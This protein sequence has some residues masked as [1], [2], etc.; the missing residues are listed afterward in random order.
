MHQLRLLEMLVRRKTAVIKYYDFKLGK[1]HL[2]GYGWP[3]LVALGILWIPLIVGTLAI[4]AT[5][6][7]IGIL[8]QIKRL[9]GM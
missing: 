7:G 8:Q 1:Y 3:G 9:L 2:R 5:P 6:A 4:P